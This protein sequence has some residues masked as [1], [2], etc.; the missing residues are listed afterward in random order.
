ML[1]R[2]FNKGRLYTRETSAGQGCTL[3]RGILVGLDDMPFQV[4]RVVRLSE[5]SAWQQCFNLE[6][7]G[8]AENALEA[9]S[10]RTDVIDCKSHFQLITVT[11]LR[12]QK[13]IRVQIPSVI[14]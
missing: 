13:I 14:P 2:G 5:P 7:L 8:I 12:G 9:L 10:I 1:V 3:K 6:G 11:R 4:R